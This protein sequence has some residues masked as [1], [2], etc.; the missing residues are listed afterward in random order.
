[1]LKHATTFALTGFAFLTGSITSSKSLGHYLNTK[2]ANGITLAFKHN[3]LQAK[4]STT[5]LYKFKNDTLIQTLTVQQLTS[6]SI[7]FSLASHNTKRNKFAQ[8][9]GE[10][11]L[12]GEH[13]SESNTDDEGY[14]FQ[15]DEYVFKRSCFIY[16]RID[17]DVFDK[18]SI[19][20]SKCKAD[21]PYSP[22]HS[23]G[24][25]TRVKIK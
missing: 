9:S 21:K 19:K 25:L 6:K 12:N 15:V 1:M 5:R 14:E 17:S 24:I 2:T 4:A 8:I 18:A 7:R 20:V 16:I 10:A 22:I 13:G 23:I 11:L 3:C